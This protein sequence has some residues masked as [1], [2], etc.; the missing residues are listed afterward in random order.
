MCSNTFIIAP[1][2]PVGHGIVK[3]GLLC[4]KKVRVMLDHVGAEDAAGKVAVLEKVCCIAQAHRNARQML[5]SVDVTLKDGRRLDTLLDTLQPSGQRSGHYQIGV[6][7]GTRHT[8]FD[9]QALAMADDA[10]ASSDHRLVWVD[11]ALPGTRCR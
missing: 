8:R 1:A 9:A 3:H 4:T 10:E 11:I 7:I 2:L 6:T 5:C